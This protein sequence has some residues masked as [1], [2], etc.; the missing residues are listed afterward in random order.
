MNK[1]IGFLNTKE[2]MN[3]KGEWKFKGLESETEKCNSRSLKY[4]RNK[5]VITC[6]LRSN[7]KKAIGIAKCN[8]KDKFNYY[9]GVLIAELRARENFYKI[10][11][12]NHIK[13]MKEKENAIHY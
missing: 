13:R 8:P 7:G 9:D 1:F 3:C 11:V 2:T 6:V 4:Y 12:E 5:N 10:T